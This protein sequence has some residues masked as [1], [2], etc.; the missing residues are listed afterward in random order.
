[1]ELE[2][3]Q[4]VL[5]SVVENQAEIELWVALD[6]KATKLRDDV[7][8]NRLTM[9]QA[10]AWLEPLKKDD[11]FGSHLSGVHEPHP[12]PYGNLFASMYFLMTGFHAVHVI[13]GMILFAIVLARGSQLNEQWTDWVEN[14]GLYW[15][16]VDLVWIFLFP[17]IYIIPGFDR[18]T[19]GH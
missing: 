10:G 14:T 8:A 16:F 11:V 1:A 4:T 13:V 6:D 19:P 7:S 5:T 12:I 3:Q 18:G 9:A 15:H 2:R 17:L